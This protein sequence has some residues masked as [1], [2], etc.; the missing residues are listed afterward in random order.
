VEVEHTSRWIQSRGR[1]AAAFA[2]FAFALLTALTLASAARS[3]I[4]APPPPQVWSDKAD[5]APGELVTLSGANWAPG[6]PVH[7]RVND[8]AGQTW[9]RDVDVVADE[10]GSFSDQFNL[11]DWFV[12]V[13]NVTAT[14]ASS[15]TATWSFTDGTIRFELAT[16]D[17]AAPS[18]FTWSV[19]WQVFS[20]GTCTA[21]ATSSGTANLTDNA[22]ASGT[23]PGGNQN[24]SAKPTNVTVTGTFA[25]Q[26]VFDYWSDSP[27]STTPSANVCKP[28]VQGGQ[29][30]TRLYAHFKPVLR[31]QLATAGNDANGVAGFTWSVNWQF[32]ATTGCMGMPGASGSASYTVNALTG[33]TQPTLSTTQ[34]VQPTGAS[35]TGSFS[36][37][38]FQY[39]S[40]SAASTTPLTGSAL[41]KSWNGS[42]GGAVTLFAHFTADA[43]PP[44]TTAT[45]SP[46][47]NGVGWN[48]TNVSV[49][50][51]AT[52]NAGGSGVKEITYSASGA[53]S[54]ASTTVAG[55][56]VTGISFTAE[57]T[58][59]LS[60]FAKDNAGNTESTKTLV[61]K[62]DKTAPSLNATAVK[63][64]APAFADGVAYSENSWTNQDVKVTFSCSDPGGSGVAAGSPSPASQTFT[65]EG[66]HTASSSCADVAGNSANKNFGVR[67]DKTAP[68]IVAT[69]TPAPN[70]NGWNNTDVTVSYVCAD[71]RSGLDPAYGNDGA[72]CWNDDH[73]SAEGTTQF[74]NRAIFDRAGNMASVSPSVFIDKTSPNLTVSHSADGDNSWNVSD[75]VTVHVNASDGGSG[76]DGAPSCEVDNSP[77]SLS[78]SG[79]WTL[80]VSGEGEHDVD[81]SVSDL[82]SNSASASDT[83]KIDTVAPSIALSH[84]A[85]AA[86]WNKTS[87]VSV[88][89]AVSDATS[90]LAGA[91]T[92]EV[93][94]SPATVTGSASPY[95][96]AVSGEGTHA[97][98]CS[99]SDE[100]GNSNSDDDEVKIDLTAPTVNCGSADGA[101]HANNVSIGCTASDGG[102]GLDNSGDASF[103]LSTSV[104]AGLETD[105]ASTNSRVVKD[106]AGNETTAGPVA[107]NKID[108]KGPAVSLTCPASPV[109]KDSAATASWSASDGGSGLVGPSSGTISLDTTSVGSHTATVPAGFKKDNVDNGSEAASCNYSVVYNWR[110]FFQPVDNLPALN[111]AKAGSAIPVKFSLGGNQGMNIFMA[112]YPSST[113]VTCGNTGNADLIESTVTAG[114]SSLNYDAAADQYNYVWKTQTTWANSCRTL[115]VKLVDG[116]V[117]QANFW[118]VK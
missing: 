39:W 66:E 22:L 50:L 110:G 97:V 70:S 15:G 95:H 2:L 55:N 33:G 43:I 5:Y 117:H 79:P 100:A 18:G 87:P 1:K 108:R 63:G 30:F 101:W 12:A 69:L 37:Y 51:N 64:T 27:T 23:N 56:S 60:F 59:T 47:A 92:C 89:I 9:S 61:I 45:P 14:G 34:G 65:A 49:N 29:N 11:P 54:I 116:T 75:P 99:V 77:A 57:G 93:D 28:G 109:L 52:D 46:A 68:T 106:K 31:F 67:I 19:D 58:T 118:F 91:P 13:Y 83:V 98:E 24:D 86:G 72:G 115:T 62:I 78:G 71:D 82:A 8:D 32:R 90:G 107:H 88:A 17:N 96:V 81:C 112:G 16:V 80:S 25:G 85:N 105:N 26:Y 73:A 103:N 44:T 10:N 113:A 102:S 114:Q 74:V 111:K 53:Q 76:L 42:A 48:K 40:D 38:T 7:I 84:T 3:E 35:A 4:E 6:E 104:A 36:S 21:P 20:G 94:G 41:C